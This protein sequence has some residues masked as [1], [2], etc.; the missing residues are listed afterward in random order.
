MWSGTPRTHRPGPGRVVP[1]STY[2]LQLHAGFGFAD[3]AAISPYLS[4]L[5]V[6]HLY[7]SPILEPQPGSTHGYDVID[8]D[9]L[10][11]QAGG[12]AGFDALVSAAHAAGLGLIV[13]VV[14]NHM[15]VPQET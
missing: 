9:S 14:P 12:A 13:D 4:E 3:A 5:G 6:S 11:S 10:N 1:T 7:L 15:T 8:H 2:R